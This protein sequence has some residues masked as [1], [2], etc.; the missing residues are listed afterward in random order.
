MR[1]AALEAMRRPFP[2]ASPVMLEP[3]MSVE[4]RMPSEYVGD[5]GQSPG[6]Q[7]RAYPRRAHGDF[8]SAISALAPMRQLFGFSTELRSRTK[9][10]AF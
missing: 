6:S 9:G 3:I 1:M 4:L 2:Q 5:C 8:D 7:E 10:K